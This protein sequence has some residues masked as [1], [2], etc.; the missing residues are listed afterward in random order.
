M[1]IRRN[2]RSRNNGENQIQTTDQ[3]I[4]MQNISTEHDRVSVHTW[5]KNSTEEQDEEEVG[6]V[7]RG[8]EE[9]EALEELRQVIHEERRLEA[10]ERANL[11]RQNQELRMENMRLQH[12]RSRSTTGSNSWSVRRE[13]RRKSPV[14]EIDEDIRGEMQNLNQERREGGEIIENRSIPRGEIFYNE[15]DNRN[16]GNEQFHE[17]NYQNGE[18]DPEEERRMLRGREARRNQQ[19]VE[20]EI[21]RQCI[22]QTRLARERQ[23]LRAEVEEQEYQEAMYQNNQGNRERSR[24]HRNNVNI[25]EEHDRI[26]RRINRQQRERRRNEQN[27]R[28]E[29]KRHNQIRRERQK[30]GDEDE[31]QD[32]AAQ[33]M[34][35]QRMRRTELKNPME[36]NF[37]VNEQIVRELVEVRGLLNSRKE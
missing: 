32:F 9:I 10:E 23:R 2:G 22:E 31:F 30:E 11:T 3:Q 19:T 33:N 26:Q 15:Q 14:M 12:R 5:K 18:E 7:I 36:Q 16:Q 27:H 34:H 20:A 24:E 17:Q 21:E 4:P 25:H 37:G 28:E 29:D 35:E 6:G 8:N 13:I 1:E